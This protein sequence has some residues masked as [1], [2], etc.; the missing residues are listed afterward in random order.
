ME[1]GGSWRYFGVL[2][3]LKGGMLVERGWRLG[4][5]VWNRFGGLGPFVC[6]EVFEVDSFLVI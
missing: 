4:L 5:G 6:W 3:S 2:R 1:T